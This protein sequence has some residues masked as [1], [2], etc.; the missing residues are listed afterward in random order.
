[1]TYLNVGESFP[2]QNRQIRTPLERQ[3]SNMASYFKSF[4]GF[5]G[6]IVLSRPVCW[7]GFVFAVVSECGLT[8]QE[9]SSA[10]GPQ[11]GTCQT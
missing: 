5:F 11:T 8:E 9:A 2:S 6:W 1:M 7:E 10:P 3:Y 4:L